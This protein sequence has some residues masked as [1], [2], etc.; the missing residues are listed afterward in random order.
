MNINI[1]FILDTLGRRLGLNGYIPC[2]KNNTFIAKAI[3]TNSGIYPNIECTEMSSE[4]RYRIEHTLRRTF[5]LLKCDYQ[6]S[7]ELLGNSKFSITLT[8]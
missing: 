5:T 1:N 4:A 8:D 7:L 6:Y 3:F 2:E